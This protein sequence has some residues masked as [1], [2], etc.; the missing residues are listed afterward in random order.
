MNT[1]LY[2]PPGTGKTTLA[3]QA[4]EAL[5]L[6]FY[7]YPMTE[8]LL[9]SAFLGTRDATGAYRETPFYKWAT[10]GGVLLIDEVSKGDPNTLAVLN[11]PL[12][13]RLASFPAA[14]T[15][16]V[17]L[18]ESCHIILADNTKGSGATADY[19]ASNRMDAALIDRCVFLRVPYDEELENTI[20][21]PTAASILHDLRQFLFDR[22]ERPLST[23][24]GLRLDRLLSSGFS[25]EKALGILLD[26]L[27]TEEK[28]AALQEALGSAASTSPKEEA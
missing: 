24:F 13:N 28:Q 18:H 12:E 11:M 16:M 2:G 25:T 15:P 20:L 22:F 17:E 3:K 26:Y 6:P 9:P 27:P 8:A 4:A 23:R 10:S 14:P 19:V 1:W 21:S 7:A 5:E